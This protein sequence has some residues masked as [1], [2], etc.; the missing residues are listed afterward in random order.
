MYIKSSDNNFNICSKSKGVKNIKSYP[1][2]FTYI[3]CDTFTSIH[4]HTH[5]HTHVHFIVEEFISATWVLWPSNKSEKDL[6]GWVIEKICLTLTGTER[7]RERDR[8][9]E[10]QRERGVYRYMTV[11]LFQFYTERL[12][13]EHGTHSWRQ[14]NWEYNEPENKK[15]PED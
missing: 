13:R 7:E 12:Q 8:D 6:I 10:R 15:E 14:N 5:T 1:S 2:T 11:L 4:T 3:L 9:R